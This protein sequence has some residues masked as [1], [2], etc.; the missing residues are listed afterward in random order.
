MGEYCRQT[1]HR[2]EASVAASEIWVELRDFFEHL[3]GGVNAFR[4]RWEWRT[5][6]A[7][8]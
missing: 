1:Q 8:K 4:N 3:G 7:Y 5:T 2:G 6:G